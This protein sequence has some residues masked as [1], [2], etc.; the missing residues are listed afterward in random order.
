ML[1]RLTLFQFKNFGGLEQL[2]FGPFTVLIGANAAGKSNLRD[3]L[4]FLHGVG[5]G[6]SIADIVGEQYE[7]GRLQWRGIRGGRREI[8]TYGQT[9]ATLHLEL[10]AVLEEQPCRFLYEISPVIETNG[11]PPLI[12]GER[13]EQI[14]PQPHRKVFEARVHDPRSGSLGTAGLLGQHQLSNTVPVLHQLQDPGL[15]LLKPPNTE[16]IQAL[17]RLVTTKLSQMR[18]FDLDPEVMRRR[19][20][21]G[22]NVLGDRG[23]Y[24]SS[25]LHHLCQDPQRKA[26]LLSWLEELT[27]MGIRDLDFVEDALTGEIVFVLIEENGQRTSAFSASDGTLRFLGILASLLSEDHDQ[28]Y[29]FEELENGIHPAQLH[30]LIQLIEEQVGAGKKQVLATTHSPQLLNFL[31]PESLAHA[32]LVYRLPGETQ[33]H[34]QPI[35]QIPQAQDLIA[36]YGSG[37]LHQSHWFEN[38]MY[39]LSEEE[40]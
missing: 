9:H 16:D 35:L 13:V 7:G 40:A 15:N 27:P 14:R 11:T 38:A 5:R 19:S 29:C 39:F 33:G 22:Q 25:V 32:A 17:L 31:S 24:L 21:P 4:R 8:I 10:Q 6:Y 36:K 2:S 20:F 23:E 1:T 26:S 30:L 34:I 37:D 3:A 18:F 12:G 28:F